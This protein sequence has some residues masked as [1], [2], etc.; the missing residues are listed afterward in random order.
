MDGSVA[1]RDG[2]FGDPLARF[3]AAIGARD[4]A[5]ANAEMMQSWVPLLSGDA[6]RRVGVLLAS[7]DVRSLSRYPLLMLRAGVGHYAAPD[8]RARSWQY[9]GLAA[10]AAHS[11]LSRTGA[12]ERI[13]LLT[14]ES[15]GLRLGGRLSLADAA[16]RAALTLLVS[17]PLDELERIG[18]LSNLLA[19][20]GRSCFEAGNVRDAT[21]AFERG[22]AESGADA[23]AGFSN[24]AMLAAIP[25]FVGELPDTVQRLRDLRADEWAPSLAEHGSG[26]LAVH[27]RL[28]EAL[29]ALERL[30]ADGANAMLE[31]IAVDRDTIEGWPSIAAVEATASLVRGDP[32]GGLEGLDAWTRRR[33]HEPGSRKHSRIAPARAALQLALGYVDSAEMTLRKDGD[34]RTPD[35]QVA[36]A[37]VSLARGR[38]HAALNILRQLGV[39][40][41]ASRLQAEA[42]AIEAAALLRLPRLPRRDAALDR[43]AALLER[44]GM[45]LPVAVLPSAD[46]ERVA[47][48]LAARG[49]ARPPGARALL[50]D[51]EPLTLTKRERALLE[52]LAE[53]DATRA[54][55]AAAMHVSVN[56]VKTQLR[57]L[58][59][60]LGVSTREAALAVAGE[61]HLFQSPDEALDGLDDLDAVR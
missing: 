48:A 26:Y 45:L 41:H 3:E 50:P 35:V 11:K 46:F 37:R 20:L 32:A 16:A 5:A 39:E 33:G 2:S 56:T 13:M 58:Y 4:L 12:A 23:R 24:L 54:S 52:A 43:L 38:L 19:Q 49:W 7:L 1:A 27:L 44:T 47:D 6:P 57:S 25:S 42:L 61:R 10:A 53:P 17:A 9:L 59:R 30:D 40:A 14:A 31:Q 15:V 34:A 55:I 51:V 22:L 36:L 29:V 21:A 18:Y 60:K 8:R 28:A